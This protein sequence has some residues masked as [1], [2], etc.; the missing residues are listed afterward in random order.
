[1]LISIDKNWHSQFM[2][3]TS[4]SVSPLLLSDS[5]SVILTFLFFY[6]QLSKGIGANMLKTGVKRR[7]TKQEL[8]NIREEETQKE[9][10]IQEKLSNYDLMM[11]RI[12]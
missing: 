9:E 1:M 2:S 4:V 12:Q 8:K 6:L 5:V 11:S 10:A 7:R 3:S